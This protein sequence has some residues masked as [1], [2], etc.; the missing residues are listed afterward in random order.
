V[1]SVLDSEPLW[2]QLVGGPSSG[3]TEAVALLGDIEDGTIGD[4]TLAGLLNWTGGP[5]KGRPSGLLRR[6]GDGHR[7]VSIMDF[8][9]V[10]ADSDRGRRAALFSLLRLAYDGHAIRENASAPVPLEWHGR[11]TVVSAVTPQIDAFSSHTDALGPRWMYCRVPELDERGRRR[12][13]RLARKHAIDK[14][15]LRR[16]AR[17]LAASAVV[18][19]RERIG[20]VKI[21][22]LDARCI[23]DAAHVCT[24]MRSDVPRDGYR[25]EV[26]GAVTREEPPRMAIML[27]ILLSGLRALGVPARTARRVM[28]RCALDSAPLVRRLALE[29]LSGGEVLTT[30]AVARVIDTD[31][32]V[33]RLALEDLELIGLVRGARR[34]RGGSYFDRA[35]DPDP[36]AVE[37]VEWTLAAGDGKAVARLAGGVFRSVCLN[38]TTP[39]SSTDE[40]HTSA[41]PQSR[42]TTEA[43]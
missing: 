31:R 32:K 30:S 39:P 17:S 14:S 20:A 12:A 5:V 15:E 3:K 43:S 13:A 41:H 21:N 40:H 19:A 29:A 35:D 36:A 1:T 11:L 9:T 25:R 10:L 2:L 24:L 28:V 23:D 7:L 38:H 42:A 8:S 6:I 27:T 37:A 16:R 26:I 18:A 33:T 34:R 22:G 4:L